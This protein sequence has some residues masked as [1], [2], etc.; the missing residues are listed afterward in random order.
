MIINSPLYDVMRKERSS[1]EWLSTLWRQSLS[2]SSAH[3]PT[4]DRAPRAL[5]LACAAS[6]PRAGPGGWMSTL[7]MDRRLSARD[8]RFGGRGTVLLDSSEERRSR[9]GETRL[10]VLSV[11]EGLKERKEFRGEMMYSMSLCELAMDSPS[12]SWEIGRSEDDEDE[13]KASRLGFA[14]P[15]RP[16][17]CLEEVEG[18][19]PGLRTRLSSVC[20][21]VLILG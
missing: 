9:R 16:S 5:T 8:V 19:L 12:L 4:L 17:T 10:T 18:S 6:L 21:S 2:T 7:I 15:C 14:R 11:G 1:C 3:P 13:G 20:L